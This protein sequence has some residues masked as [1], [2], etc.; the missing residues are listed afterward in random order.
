VA[1][2][3]FQVADRTRSK[4]I[5]LLQLYCRAK[6]AFRATFSTIIFVICEF[7]TLLELLTKSFGKL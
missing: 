3:D 7:L 1:A 4:E 5:T 2:P 6:T